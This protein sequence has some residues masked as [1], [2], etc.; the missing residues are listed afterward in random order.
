MAAA[1]SAT[2]Q[3]QTATIIGASLGS[4]FVLVCLALGVLVLLYM[5]RRSKKTK[6]MLL[7]KDTMSQS[8]RKKAWVESHAPF[9][10]NNPIMLSKPQLTKNTGSSP[11]SDDKDEDIKIPEVINPLRLTLNDP[12]KDQRS[13]PAVLPA[14][15]SDNS[16]RSEYPNLPGVQTQRGLFL[17]PRGF[18]GPLSGASMPV[19]TP[20]SLDFKVNL[21]E[22]PTGRA[23]GAGV[24]S[25]SKLA[26]LRPQPSSF[27]VNNPLYASRNGLSDVD[28]Q[29]NRYPIS[30]S[31]L[32]GRPSETEDETRVFFTTDNLRDP[33]APE[34]VRETEK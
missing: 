22:A 6:G 3:Q 13:K 34:D 27:Y 16:F 29:S 20:S 25:N 14:E 7:T 12:T 19:A 30:Q 2:T 24:A 1:A 31:T 4:L 21:R 33:A 11:V 15:S 10:H 17:E 23:R 28:K 9:I 18:T 5:R 26:P 32:L 8:S